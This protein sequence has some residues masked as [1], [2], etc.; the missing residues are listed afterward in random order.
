MDFQI[1]PVGRF[2]ELDLGNRQDGLKTRPTG[3]I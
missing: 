3:R 1:R 2:S